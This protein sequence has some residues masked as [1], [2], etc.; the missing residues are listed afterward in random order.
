MDCEDYHGITENLRKNNREL[1]FLLRQL[2]YSRNTSGS[3][4]CDELD[5]WGC[6]QF[7][8]RII[9]ALGDNITE[10]SRVHL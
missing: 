10:N 9:V 1:S 4:L 8:Q 7:E 6:S 2:F 3:K 5:Q